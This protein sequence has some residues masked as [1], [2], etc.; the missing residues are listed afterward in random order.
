MSARL[1]NTVQLLTDI[2][3]FITM[4]SADYVTWLSQAYAAILLLS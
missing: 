2:L 3:H 1:A 4:T